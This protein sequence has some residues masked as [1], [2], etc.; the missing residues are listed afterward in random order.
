LLFIAGQVAWDES[1]RIVSDDFV[2]QF[3]CA[4]A[5]VLSVVAEAGGQPTD[6]TRL[7]MYVTSRE[8]YRKRTEELG[9]SYRSRMGKHFPA[10]VLVEVSGLLD[11]A[12][13]VEIEGIAVLS[14]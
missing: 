6:V 13:K 12:A 3:D 2:H 9:A 7:V 1:Q 4:L 5:N 10:M 14:L 11:E 8:E